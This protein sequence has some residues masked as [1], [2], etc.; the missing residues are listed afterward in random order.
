MP[1]RQLH[2]VKL[3]AHHGL[4]HLD[5]VDRANSRFVHLLAR[6]L[7]A[8]RGRRNISIA[9]E[10]PAAPTHQVEHHHD[11]PDDEH[12]DRPVPRLAEAVVCPVEAAGI[13][14][15]QGG[16]DADEGPVAGRHVLN[17][18][19]G[20]GVSTPSAALPPTY[21]AALRVADKTGVT[22][23]VA[24]LPRDVKSF[25]LTKPVSAEFTACTFLALA[26]SG[27]WLFVLPLELL[28]FL[29]A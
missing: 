20:A 19:T 17:V 11:R 22:T 23:A 15:D 16:E 18:V 14:V 4:R 3:V 7:L 5:R 13:D 10:M 1:G 25:R 21:T 2:R 24:T 28:R 12:A 8:P 9:F 26:A 29:S 6:R 27:I